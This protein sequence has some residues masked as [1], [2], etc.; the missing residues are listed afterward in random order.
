MRLQKQIVRKRQ[1]ARVGDVVEVMIDGPS[2][3]SDL[4]LQGRLQGQAPDIDPVVYLSECDPTT[5]TAGE[6][7]SARVIG[8]KDYD[9]IVSAEL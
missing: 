1:R 3:D 8:S 7:I 5:V 2:A 9:L 6:I 4:V